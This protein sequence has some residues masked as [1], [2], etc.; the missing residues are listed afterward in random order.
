MILQP[1]V[2]NALKYAVEVSNGT[3]TIEIITKVLGEELQID[4]IDSGAQEN[5]DDTVPSFGIGLSNT[6]TRLEYLYA[7]KHSLKIIKQENGGTN[8]SLTLPIDKI[9]EENDG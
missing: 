6:R 7:N 9:I 4:I 5:S 8:V 1:L 3:G 2:E